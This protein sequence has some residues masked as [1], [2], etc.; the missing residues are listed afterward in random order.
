M[1][2]TNEAWKLEFSVRSVFS[3]IVFDVA[4]EGLSPCDTRLS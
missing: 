3:V 4:N 1:R 2:V